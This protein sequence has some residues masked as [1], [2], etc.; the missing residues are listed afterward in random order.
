M[1]YSVKIDGFEGPL[2][3][4][5][6]LIQRLEIDIY[7][8]PVSEITKQYLDYI[9]AM[10]VLRLD[11]ASEY[12]VMAATLLEIKS[13]MLLPN[14][15]E[16]A[17]ELEDVEAVDPREELVFRLIEY[18]KFKE[19]AQMLKEREKKQSLLFTRAPYDVSVYCQDPEWDV[20]NVTMY[21][22]LASLQRLMNKRLNKRSQKAT[23]EMEAITVQS[24]MNDILSE[25]KTFGG[26]KRFVDLFPY[27][28]REHLVV[29]FLAILEL[30]K[31]GKIVCE[32]ERNFADI[33]VRTQKGDE[34]SSR[35][36]KSKQ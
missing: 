28:N 36:K 14:H 22:L 9:H 25:L 32:Q 5:L 17:E 7:D 34:R 10:Q 27:E 20:V 2:D 15:E 6:H 11:I 4:L 19:A 23:I 31:N 26:R 1:Q 13:K 16:S 21:D 35:N 18:R 3:L 33:F 29:T 30:I 8:I 24:R 12:L